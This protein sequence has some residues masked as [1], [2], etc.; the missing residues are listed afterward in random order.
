VAYFLGSSEK[1]ASYQK[2]RRE[3]T[4][5][6]AGSGEELVPFPH[7]RKIHAASKEANGIRQSRGRQ[8]SQKKGAKSQAE[9]R[10][11]GDIAFFYANIY[12]L[13]NNM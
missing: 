6:L 8:P 11:D 7:E 1:L 12:K 10:G 9:S 3:L 13:I 5:A 4:I 2:K